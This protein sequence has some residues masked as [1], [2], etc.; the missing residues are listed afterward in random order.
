[1][2]RI[3]VTIDRLVLKGFDTGREKA[4]AEGLQAELARALGGHGGPADWARSRSTLSIR[5]EPVRI[6]RDGAGRETGRA[7]ARKIGHRLKP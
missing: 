3:R 2:S 4:L 7:I 5:V 1:M 6:G